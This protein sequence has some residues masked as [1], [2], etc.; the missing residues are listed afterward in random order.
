MRMH[1]RAGSGP[2]GQNARPHSRSLDLSDIDGARKRSAPTPN[3]PNLQL[4]VRDIT[5]G[6]SVG[7]NGGW[8]CRTQG[9]GGLR[10]RWVYEA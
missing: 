6:G 9:E 1:V 2:V 5:V 10:Q 3:K 7:H 8:V 4:D